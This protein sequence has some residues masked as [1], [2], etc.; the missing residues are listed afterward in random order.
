MFI[1]PNAY[2]KCNRSNISW[3]STAR[4][5][6]IENQIK[7]CESIRS[8]SELEFWYSMLGTQLVQHGTESR[9][10][11]YLDD[12]LGLPNAFFSADAQNEEANEILVSDNNKTQQNW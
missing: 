9:L 8:P 4:L 3:Q 12:L 11:I 5:S 1:S 2:I 6:F 10:R 7:I